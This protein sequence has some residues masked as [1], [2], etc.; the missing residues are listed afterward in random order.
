VAIAINESVRVMTGSRPS[1]RPRRRLVRA[2]IERAELSLTH[3]GSTP[4][5]DP[6]RLVVWQTLRDQLQAQLK[7]FREVQK[8]AQRS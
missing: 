3:L 7:K 2:V 5:V 4:P 8:Q 1:L 6:D